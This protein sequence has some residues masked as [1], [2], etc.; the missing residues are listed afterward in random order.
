[1]SEW[2]GEYKGVQLMTTRNDPHDM[3][4]RAADD[5]HAGH[6]RWASRARTSWG[7][8]PRRPRGAALAGA[9]LGAVPAHAA[10]AGS[11]APQVMRKGS[12]VTLT[13]YFGANPAEAQLR[14]KLFN[15]F[16]PPTPTS[17]SSPSS[18]A[19]RTCRSSTPRSPAATRP[20]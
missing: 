3:P 18:T 9:G 2:I 6:G 19:P 17:R 5:T 14:Q 7:W 1:M 16:R 11:R 20:T 10:S 8:P 13:Y 12:Q 15:Q 4:E